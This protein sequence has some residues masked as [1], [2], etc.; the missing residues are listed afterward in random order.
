MR[1][2]EKNNVNRK[3]TIFSQEGKT[4]GHS[5]AISMF[6]VA[7]ISLTGAKK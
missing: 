6:G 1:I 5:L 2:I 4:Q 3:Q 7:I